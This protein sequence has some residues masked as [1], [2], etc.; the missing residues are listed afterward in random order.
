MSSEGDD[1]YVIQLRGG[2]AL[3]QG[4]EH[5]EGL[6]KRRFDEHIALVALETVEAIVAG[7]ADP[8]VDYEK[9]AAALWPSDEKD[10]EKKTDRAEYDHKN[11]RLTTWHLRK[12]YPDLL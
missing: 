8:A 2:F 6:Q 7:E 12:A 11:V 3:W 9:I 5:V 1:R 10:D 4:Q